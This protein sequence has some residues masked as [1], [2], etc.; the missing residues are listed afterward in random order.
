MNGLLGG[1]RGLLGENAGLKAQA[2]GDTLIGLSQNRQ[3]QSPAMTALMQRQAR[4]Q[5][6]RALEESGILS[7]FSPE[8]RAMLVAME[9]SA[10][11]QI[12]A[13]SVFREPPKPKIT[14][15]MAE[16]DF[17]RS[18][19]FKGSFADWMIENRRAGA[20]NV[21]VNGNIPKPPE[22]YQYSYDEKGNAIGYEPVPGGPVADEQQADFE[23]GNAA[24][25]LAREI[26]NDPALASITGNLQ[27]RLPA[28][29]PGITGG[30]AGSN[31][32][33]KIE[34]L[35]GQTFL[36]A[37]QMLKGGGQIT[38]I[39]GLKAERAMARLNQAQS[40]DA[41]Q[42]SLDDFIEAVETGMKKLR[43]GGSSGGDD[44]TPEE[45]KYLGIDD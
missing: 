14:D 41:F 2:I 29:L 13:Q 24:A 40:H 16:F 28:G 9:P 15:D 43:G 20:S 38:E 10:A 5:Q 42:E 21:T 32:Q 25:S 45:R 30:Q 22:G 17:A 33:A 26:R 35:Q 7:R 27:G 36:Q 12:I 6:Q 39:E 1:I 8:E 11:M 37:Y 44:L 18:Q 31:L 19:G 34:Q 4:A 23:A 3:V